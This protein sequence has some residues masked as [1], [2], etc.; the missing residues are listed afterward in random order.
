MGITVPPTSLILDLGDVLFTWSP[1]TE[2][3]ITPRVVK[4]ILQSPTWFDFERGHITQDECHARVAQE[5][6]IARD[7]LH[8]A[9]EQARHSFEP[10]N[11]LVD[12]IRQLKAES[13]GTLRVYALSN[14]SVPDL[15]YLRIK[16]GASWSIFDAVFASGLIGER[17]PH[18]GIFKHVISETNIDPQTTVFVDDKPDNVLSARSLGMCG[19][20]FTAADEAMRALGNIFGDPVQRG[21]RYLYQNAQRLQSVTGTGDVLLE[22]FSQLLILELTG[23]R[24]LVSIKEHSLTWNLFQ[25]ISSL[26]QEFPDDLDTTSLAMTALRTGPEIAN[27]VM[28]EMLKYK[29]DDGIIMTYFDFGR[30]R[31]CPFVAANVLTM[32]YT[33]GRGHELEETLSWIRDVLKFRAYTEGSRYYHSADIFLYLINR[34]VLCSND[35]LLHQELENLLSARVKER[36]GTAGNALELALRLIVCASLGITNDIDTSRLL[37][38]QCHDGGWDDGVCCLIGATDLAIKNRGLTTAAA[39]R[40]ISMIQKRTGATQK[41]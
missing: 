10:D 4:N 24:A 40:A 7:E 29:D 5:F 39:V 15:D 13:G 3:S 34:L 37:S 23:D 31:I 30:Q 14:I 19:V 27:N 8:R 33:Y 11:R 9:V 36:V 26:Y 35:Q 28:N 32:F 2:T 41:Y 38:M 20:I 25:E 1:A 16:A 17:K 22:N 21:R 12:F 6:S 18:L